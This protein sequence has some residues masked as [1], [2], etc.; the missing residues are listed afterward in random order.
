MVVSME[1]WDG[2]VAM[3][4]GASSG[5]GAAIAEKLVQH[6]MKVKQLKIYLKLKTLYDVICINSNMS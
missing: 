2:K 1:R 5:I 4:T 3:V 6:G